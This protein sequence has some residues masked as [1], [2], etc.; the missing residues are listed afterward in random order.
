MLAGGV[1]AHRY[2]LSSMV[3]LKDN[4][5]W[6]ASAAAGLKPG[7]KGAITQAVKKARQAA[8]FALRIDVEV[9]SEAEAEEAV[10][11]GADVV[12][13]DN[14][15]GEE[16]GA[17]ARRLKNR[18]EGQAWEEALQNG[19]LGF[20]GKRTF[21]LE[22]SGGIDVKNIQSGGHLDNGEHKRR[23][24]QT[25]CVCSRARST[26]SHRYYQHKFDSSVYQ[27]CRL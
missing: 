8:G 13:L 18:Y 20:S 26:H 19:E 1:D 25:A 10:E 22:S 16:L 9:Q 15:S 24:T 14:M 17:C 27:A 2:D 7:E 21:L 11:A 4:H 23:R 12:M 6:S 3:M 5:I